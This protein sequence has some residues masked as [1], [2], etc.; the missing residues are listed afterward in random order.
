MLAL[1]ALAGWYW[2]NS[3]GPRDDAAAPE[4]GGQTADSGAAM[5]IKGL[6]IQQ[7]ENGVEL[8]RLKAAGAVMSQQGGDIVAEKP[9]LTYY[10]AEDNLENNTGQA[11]VAERSVITVQSDAGDVNQ[12]E[13]RIR[14]VGRVVAKHE[15]DTLE[16]EVILYEGQQKHLRCP[17][18]SVL[19]RPGMR[20][21]ANTM[22]WNLSDNTLH[23][24]NGVSI[25]I[26]TT[27]APGEALMPGLKQN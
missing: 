16:T 6:E 22:L 7:G 20:G 17:E 18:P 11:Q 19:I 23:A 13:N 24:Q 10:F 26:E 21:K 12:K 15:D 14:F 25:D 5:S 3:T 8:W 4:A 1:L 9:F 2:W 27:R